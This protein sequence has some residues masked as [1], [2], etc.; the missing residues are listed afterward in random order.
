MKK[1]IE[2][3][4]QST[5]IIE[6]EVP[7]YYNG[8]GIYSAITESSIISV[9]RNGQHYSYTAAADR[10]YSENIAMALKYDPPRIA[11]EEFDSAM[12]ITLKCLTEQY[13]LSKEMSN[14][15]PN[16]TQAA[17]NQE[18][19]S[20]QVGNTE[21]AKEQ[22]TEETETEVEAETGEAVAAE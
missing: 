12:E 8:H 9:S 6:V 2:I 21:Q 17:D 15:D 18:A 10:F 1:R 20:E 14:I 7:S 22:A 5:R 16:A 13:Q 11:K 19:P 3:T 4:E